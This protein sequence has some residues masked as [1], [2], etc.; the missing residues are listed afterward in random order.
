MGQSDRAV[1]DDWQ[2]VSYEVN[3]IV[4]ICRMRVTGTVVD[5]HLHCAGAG[6]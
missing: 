6:G 1:L 4:T 5:L 3:W 2:P